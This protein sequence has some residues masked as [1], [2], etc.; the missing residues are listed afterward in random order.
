MVGMRLRMEIYFWE[1]WGF[2]VVFYI[3]MG[4][5]VMKCF[6]LYL[7]IGIGMGLFWV[8]LELVMCLDILIDNNG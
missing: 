8:F 3:D 6:G 7:I 2:D 4:Y 1:I 5:F